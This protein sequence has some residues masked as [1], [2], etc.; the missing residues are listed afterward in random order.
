MNVEDEH[1]PKLMRKQK[2][3][4]THTHCVGCGDF[5]YSIHYGVTYGCTTSVFHS[6]TTCY[7][8]GTINYAT[9]CGLGL[10]TTGSTINSFALCV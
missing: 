10:C 1:H 6:T 8:N 7:H 2:K 4:A 3:C 5:G 9:Y